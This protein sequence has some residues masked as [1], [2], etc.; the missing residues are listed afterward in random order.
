MNES[1]AMNRMVIIYAVIARWNTVLTQ[2]FEMAQK[3]SLVMLLI[4]GCLGAM[5]GAVA[6]RSWLGGDP[7]AA[8]EAVRAMITEQQSAWN[9]GNLAG[10]L[11]HYDMNDSITFYHD[12]VIAAGWVQ[13]SDR[14]TTKYVTN[15]VPMGTLEFRDVVVEPYASDAV[16]ARGR[17][18][19][20][21]HDGMTR[22]GLF[23][24][25]VRKTDR[26]WKIV[27]DHTSDR[28]S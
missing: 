9:S 6:M 24:I 17:W 4:G 3:S 26:G 28:R 2:E 5:I 12:D 14:F 25:I 10:F 27:H 1:S 20:T 16:M 15:K 11:S 23:T 8:A 22:G 13:L 18:G 19:T 21:V 7:A